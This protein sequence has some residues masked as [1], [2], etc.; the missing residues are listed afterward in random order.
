[1]K[2]IILVSLVIGTLFSTTSSADEL[3]GKHS[4][5]DE[6]MEVITVTPNYLL[7]DAMRAVGAMRAEV[8][9][10]EYWKEEF[11]N[12]VKLLMEDQQSN[13]VL[14]TKTIIDVGAIDQNNSIQKMNEQSDLY[15]ANPVEAGAI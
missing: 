6:K 10:R 9:S 3:T 12:T 14:E 8:A 5:Q 2:P 1:M 4:Q 11:F 13:S 7:L 15:Q